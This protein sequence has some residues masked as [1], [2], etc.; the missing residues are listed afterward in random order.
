MAHSTEMYPVEIDP[1]FAQDLRQMERAVNYRHWQFNMVAPFVRGRVLE[2]GGGIGNF[3]PQLATIAGSMVSI[4]PNEYCHRQLLEK[5]KGVANIS[6]HRIT[7]EALDTVLAPGE[8]FDSIVVM[9]VLEHI[10]DDRGVLAA[11]KDRLADGGQ[12]V[13]LVP[14]GPWAFGTTDDRLGHYRRYAKG[15]ARQLYRSLGLD[16]ASL[17][18]YN[19]IGIWAWWW[20]ARLLRRVN[21]SDTQI[22][23]FDRFLVPVISWVERFIRP[24]VGQSILMVGRLPKKL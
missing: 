16:M 5:I 14:A 23:F 15:Y 17:R 2:V 1:F 8:K 6:A 13:V 3:T 22:Q 18:Y 11:L 24:P 10:Q 12:I 4:E 19:F 7:V 20:N 21:Q 9:N